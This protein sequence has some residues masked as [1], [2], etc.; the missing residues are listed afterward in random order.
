M[1]SGQGRWGLRRDDGC[2]MQQGV[3]V[4]H[5]SDSEDCRH[6]SKGIRKLLQDLDERNKI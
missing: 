5:L 2:G 1:E 6:P 4:D 3:T